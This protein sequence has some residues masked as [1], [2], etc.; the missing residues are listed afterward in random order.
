[1][2]SL[3]KFRFLFVVS[4][5]VFGLCGVMAILSGFKKRMHAHVSPDTRLLLKI[6]HC[7]RQPFA[8]G[9]ESASSVVKQ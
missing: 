9:L 5:S 3:S 1:M 2:L 6:E 7:S 8:P 4:D